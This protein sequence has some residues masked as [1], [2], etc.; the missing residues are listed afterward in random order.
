MLFLLS[1]EAAQTFTHK[2][3]TLLKSQWH[4]WRSAYVCWSQPQISESSLELLKCLILQRKYWFSWLIQVFFITERHSQHGHILFNS[5]PARGLPTLCKFTPLSS[6]S[7]VKHMLR[8]HGELFLYK[9]SITDLLAMT[10]SHRKAFVGNWISHVIISSGIL[11][12]TGVCSLSKSEQ[13]I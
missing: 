2:I 1:L 7:K 11:P 9:V 13:V 12:Q 3:W 8:L 6:L 10:I 5:P 4:Y